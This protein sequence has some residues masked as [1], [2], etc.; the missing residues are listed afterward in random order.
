MQG[1]G[2]F[3]Q[4]NAHRGV[5]CEQQM[6]AVGWWRIFSAGFPE[7]TSVDATRF[8]LSPSSCSA[9]RRFSQQKHLQSLTRNRLAQKKVK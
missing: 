7:L 2:T 1:S 8:S 9:K 6:P 3:E 5:D 4:S